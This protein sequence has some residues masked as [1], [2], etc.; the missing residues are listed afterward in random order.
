MVIILHSKIRDNLLAIIKIFTIIAPKNNN[1]D[2]LLTDIFLTVMPLCRGI[3]F[4]LILKIYFVLS[5]CDNQEPV[6]RIHIY[7]IWYKTSNK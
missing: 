1:I 5:K 3:R 2:Y 7:V 4:I 6:V